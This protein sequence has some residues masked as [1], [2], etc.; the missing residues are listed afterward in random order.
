MD[1]IHPV[2]PVEENKRL[3]E[4]RSGIVSSKK[5]TVE[6]TSCFVCKHPNNTISCNRC[7]KKVCGDCH[8][9]KICIICNPYDE[10]SFFKCCGFN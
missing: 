9:N 4:R 5:V 7:S 1:R 6:S 3:T 2:D 10:P 8:D